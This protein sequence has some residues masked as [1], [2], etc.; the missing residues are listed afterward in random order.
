MKDGDAQQR[1]E[2]LRSLRGV[3]PNMSEGSCGW[4]IGK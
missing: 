2:I 3:F 4:H 1:N